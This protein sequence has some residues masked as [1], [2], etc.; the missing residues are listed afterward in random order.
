VE[1][2]QD[3]AKTLQDV[4]GS[5]NEEQSGTK[6]REPVTEE[7]CQLHEGKT[8]QKNHIPRDE[9]FP[10]QQLGPV[11]GTKLR[12]VAGSS[13]KRPYTFGQM[14]PSQ[15]V[16]VSSVPWPFPRRPRRAGRLNNKQQ[17]CLIFRQ[18]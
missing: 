17:F 6:I 15:P 10:R 13:S 18:M 8:K 4:L 2:R 7:T 12:A 9:R 16:T 5:G 3:S 14:F 1:R 11:A